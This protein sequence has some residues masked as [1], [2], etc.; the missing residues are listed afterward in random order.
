MI[1]N[2]KLTSTYRPI[3]NMQI[4]NSTFEMIMFT[5]KMFHIKFTLRQKIPDASIIRDVCYLIRFAVYA[6]EHES[7]TK[8][9]RLIMNPELLNPEKNVGTLYS[10]KFESDKTSRANSFLS[11]AE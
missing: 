2:V 7:D 11:E 10:E 5:C 1:P 6:M 9:Y 4:L 8:L 3:S